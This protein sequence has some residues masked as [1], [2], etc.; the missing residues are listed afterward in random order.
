MDSSRLLLLLSPPLLLVAA[1]VA[2]VALCLKCL[3]GSARR[4]A[5]AALGLA[6]GVAAACL[7]Y[8]GY[9]LIG[10]GRYAEF[11]D[12]QSRL[13]RMPGVQLLDASG[14]EDVSFEIGG[15]TID[16]EDRGEIAFGALDRDSFDDADHLPIYSIGGYKV[17]V[18][19]EG[20][21]GV[22]R[23]ESGEPVR[24]TGWGSGI[25]VGPEGAFSRLFPFPLRK[26]QHVVDRYEEIC[27]ELASWPVQPEY[28]TFQDEE[29]TNYYYSVKDPALDE[30][31]IYPSELEEA[32][33]PRGR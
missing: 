4:R 30:A 25:D 21:L 19:R 31:W 10:P 29:G 22:Y 3:R 11:E 17:I 15:F 8:H 9:Y 2:V 6:L 18:V 27:N 20:Y 16:V 23:I 28:G 14:H 12:I 33:L 24:G 13:R 7:G 32:D 26:V 1:V 5:L